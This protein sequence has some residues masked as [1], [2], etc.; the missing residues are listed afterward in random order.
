MSNRD[1]PF[2]FSR[3]HPVCGRI[4]SLCGHTYFMAKKPECSV[5]GGAIRGMY[6]SAAVE[7]LAGVG[8]LGY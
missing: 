4:D 5:A 3:P 6:L 8:Q 7:F 2:P 1:V